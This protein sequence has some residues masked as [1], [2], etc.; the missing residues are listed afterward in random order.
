MTR[1]DFEL[2]AEVLK[3]SKPLTRLAGSKDRTFQWHC[4]VE[5]F[6][7]RLATTNGNFDRERFL[8]ACGYEE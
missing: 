1:K 8:R 4:M 5:E 6:A 3:S 7:S 2:I